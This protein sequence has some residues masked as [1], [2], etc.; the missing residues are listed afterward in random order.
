MSSSYYKENKNIYS[1]NLWL[2]NLVN[3]SSNR[4]FTNNLPSP[5]S[6]VK[7]FVTASSCSLSMIKIEIETILTQ[8][9]IHSVTAAVTGCNEI[10][11]T[12][13][14][15]KFSDKYKNN[16]IIVFLIAFIINAPVKILVSKYMFLINRFCPVHK[17]FWIAQNI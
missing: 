4:R 15:K 6:S 3:Y 8:F 14:T 2:V 9:Q 17:F 1:K 12:M 5:S 16:Y 13:S 7:S 11:C 10:I